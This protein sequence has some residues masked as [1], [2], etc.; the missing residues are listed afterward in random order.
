MMT[1]LLELSVLYYHCYWCYQCY[2]GISYEPVPT[3]AQDVALEHAWIESKYDKGR[4]A[5]VTGAICLH[6]S[7]NCH[8]VSRA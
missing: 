8:L 6:V 1:M 7:A 2:D 3:T 5:H 4:G